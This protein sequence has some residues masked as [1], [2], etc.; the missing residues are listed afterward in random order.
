MGSIIARKRADGTIAYLAKIAI[1]RGDLMFREARTFDRRPAA[2]A[3]IENR[4][5]ELAQPGA[6]ERSIADK[7]DPILAD[8]P[9]RS[10]QQGCD[11]AITIAPYWLARVTIAWVSVSSSSRCV[12][13]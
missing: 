5:K 6:L 9:A 7:N 12:G 4:E 1:M 2:N 11:P 3:W 8:A 10:S 13:R